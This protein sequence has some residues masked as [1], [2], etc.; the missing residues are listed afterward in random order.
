MGRLKMGKS[1][2]VLVRCETYDV[3][4]VRGAVRRGL[5][6]L[7]G[8][9]RFVKAGQRV[10]LKP[11]LL[12]GEVPEKCVTTH[13]SVF[14]AVAGA[15]LEAGASV[16]Y[17]DSP[18]IGSTAGAA[19]KAGLT[20]VAEEMGLREADFRTPVE[21]FHE[22]GVQNRKFVIARAVR[23]CDVIIS[24]P[25]LKTHGFEKYTGCVKNQFGCIPGVRKG[26]Y[27]IKLPNADDFARMLVDL[28]TLVAP[29]LYVMDGILAMEG[30]GPRGG[31]P[32]AMNIILLSTDPIAL[33]ATVCRLIGLDPALVPTVKFGHLS[34][35]GTRLPGEIEL[36]GDDMDGFVRDDFVIDR[37]PLRPYRSSGIM[38]FI[39]NRLV[40]K[41]HIIESKC[42]SCGQCVALCPTNP[43]SV[44]WAGGDT[45]RPPAH[46]YRTCI[47]CYCCQ[48]ICPESAIELR[49]PLLRKV[50]R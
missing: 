6:Y 9:G 47:R 27:H 31:K 22:K 34:G 49:Y 18:S 1:R 42:V 5:E 41:P 45:S 12:I 30:N 13:P 14:R 36:L 3:D 10:L 15:F 40:P 33:D 39:N 8:A 17:G 48:E 4:A 50:F 21:V 16:S 20:A 11:N 24:L 37:K 19:R 28:N 26:E 43:K 38:R 29:A 7:G 2:V 32:R 23:E 44:D 46:R 25:K 35:A